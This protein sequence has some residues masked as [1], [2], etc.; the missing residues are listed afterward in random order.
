MYLSKVTPTIH[1]IHRLKRQ[2]SGNLFWEHQMVWDLFDNTT[3]QTRDFLYRREDSPGK[4]PFY[5]VLSE[6]QPNN[7][8]LDMEIQSKAFHPRLQAG[9]RLQFSLR[10][11][12]VI[13]RKVDDH[14]NK[15]QRR[16]IIEAR[17]DEY[18][19]QYPNPQDRP[20][21]S[22]I[23]QEAAQMWLNRQGEN[24]GFSV[25]EFF[26]ENHTFHKVR[27]PKDANTR[28]FT[29]LDF[30]GQLIVNAPDQF[31][32]AMKNGLG[33][34]KAFGCGLMLVKRI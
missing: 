17:V 30:Q 9:E 32:R 26:V 27:K 13:T 7:A 19:K 15:R 29:S 14:S 1:A 18:K 5:Y 11:N 25:G 24:N 20:P 21:P 8:G 3:E 34:S 28:Q 12:A 4:L 2:F 16:D 23:H 33:R 22:I 10:A 6:R 31:L